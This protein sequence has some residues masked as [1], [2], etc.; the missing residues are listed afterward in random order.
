MT[1]VFEHLDDPHPPTLDALV[2]QQIARRARRLRVR[3]RLVIAA[4]AVAAV[5]AAGVI[6]AQLTT[7]GR[8]HQVQ[9]ISPTTPTF[10]AGRVVAAMTVSPHTGLVGGQQIQVTVRGFPPHVTVGLS[11]CASTQEVGPG[12]C[13]APVY[14]GLYTDAAGMATGVFIA[15]PAAYGPTATA[16]TVCHQ[17]CVLVA[18]VTKVP[19]GVPHGATPIVT[20]P[21]S[22][23]A[24]PV[25]SLAD[26]S[27]L[28]LT[29]VSSQDGWALA[30]QPC[31]RGLCAR[32][33]HTT[34]GGQ[35]WQALPDPPALVQSG[36]TDC[37]KTACVTNL[38]FASP[39]V[40]Y[41][42]GPALLI[43]TD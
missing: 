36:T 23:S 43:T 33:A 12:G 21:L 27:L 11:E 1:G 9:T 20:M 30:D 14:T 5:I 7:T 38:R 10:P 34:D 29:W 25:T 6:I 4:P 24:A 19:G 28:D 2:R 22:F 32:V 15:Q 40:G 35:H 39:T 41:L 37:T 26:A 13:K 31:T 16:S 8:I 42:Y 18:V 3:R 17:Q